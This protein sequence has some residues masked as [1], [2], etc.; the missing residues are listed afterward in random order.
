MLL[1]QLGDKDD[2]FGVPEEGGE[3]G[4]ED[5]R[6]LEKSH[7]ERLFTLPSSEKKVSFSPWNEDTP[8]NTWDN[9]QNCCQILSEGH[10]LPKEKERTSFADDD[11]GKKLF[12]LDLSCKTQL[13]IPRAGDFRE[14][15]K[16]RTK[17]MESESFLRRGHP[18]VLPSH[19]NF[20][21]F[22]LFLLLLL[23]LLHHQSSSSSFVS[24]F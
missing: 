16:V 3:G 22:F 2:F 10:R 17:K 5:S 18:E 12:S 24:F 19:G 4:G 9:D 1:I 13:I 11:D 20:F 7:R 8:F 6:Q 15:K 14:K 21:F 23:L